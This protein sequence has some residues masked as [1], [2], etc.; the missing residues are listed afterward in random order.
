MAA[1]PT[2]DP[3]LYGLAL[4]QELLAFAAL[5]S[6]EQ[7]LRHWLEHQG[8]VDAVERRDTAQL[9]DWLMVGLS[10][11]GISDQIALGYIA[12]HGSVRYQEI[13]QALAGLEAPCP[14]LVSF[15][16]FVGC[17]YRKLARTC[18]MPELLPGCPLPRHPL[19]LSLHVRVACRRRA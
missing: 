6:F 7:D 14:K 19:S 8:V 15:A 2:V 13:A 3:P 17:G 12:T 18:A 4:I 9:F 16:G 5:P 10:L 1:E 11:R